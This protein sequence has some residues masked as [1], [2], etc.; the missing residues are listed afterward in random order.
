MFEIL[1][2]DMRISD[3]PE[4]MNI[5]QISFSI[6]WSEN[7]FISEIQ[8]HYSYSRVAVLGDTIIG[9][10]CASLVIDEGHILNLAVHPEFRRCGIATHLFKVILDELK[11]TCCNKIFLEVRFSNESARKFYVKHGFGISGV[12]KNYYALPR[13]DA[14][15]MMLEL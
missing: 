11:T 12:R 3:I 4:I 5:E 10:I 1:I 8:N 2:R 9:Y 15:I 7:S 13:E 6:P 14:V